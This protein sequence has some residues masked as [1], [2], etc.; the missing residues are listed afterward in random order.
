VADL[1]VSDV[2]LDGIARSLAQISVEFDSLHDRRDEDAPIWGG[3]QVRA[4]MG[5]FATNWDV[6]REAL[7]EQIRELG[8]KCR[9]IAEEFRAVDRALAA[10]F[11]QGPS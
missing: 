4:A 1:Q 8:E 9:E 5:H 10:L 11:D 2:V 3:T 7:T 6:H